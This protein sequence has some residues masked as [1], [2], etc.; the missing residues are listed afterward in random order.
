MAAPDPADLDFTENDVSINAARQ[1]AVDSTQLTHT[2]RVKYPMLDL[3]KPGEN[4]IVQLVGPYN[5]ND[6]FP[7]EDLVD[8]P[9]V[10]NIAS[11]LNKQ[12][13]SMFVQDQINPRSQTFTDHGNAPRLAPAQPGTDDL[14]RLLQDLQSFQKTVGKTTLKMVTYMPADDPE[15]EDRMTVFVKRKSQARTAS[16]E[17]TTSMTFYEFLLTRLEQEVHTSPVTK[18]MIQ[19]IYRTNTRAVRHVKFWLRVFGTNE[20]EGDSF[21]LPSR[22]V[23][24]IDFLDPLLDSVSRADLS[25]AEV[26]ECHICLGDFDDDSHRPVRVR[27]C[28]HIFGDECFRKWFLQENV[29]NGRRKIPQCPNRCRILDETSVRRRERN[30]TF[31]NLPN[32]TAYENFE[33]ALADLDA[34]PHVRRVQDKE[35][36]VHGEVM[37][38]ALTH[39]RRGEL[40]E[41]ASSTPIHLQ[42]GRFPETQLAVSVIREF[43]RVNDGC[44]LVVKELFNY[45]HI[46]IADE[47]LVKC[48]NSLY[49]EFL[50]YDDRTA[51]TVDEWANYPVAPVRLG[52]YEYVDRLIHRM[53]MF[54][55]LRGCECQAGFHQHGARLFWN[56]DDYPRKEAVQ[57]KSENL[58]QEMNELMADR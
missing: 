5:A 24:F 49:P 11:R 14:T 6:R 12:E 23:K 38:R 37:E 10:V 58:R 52:F 26:N 51:M 43:L 4:K 30:G 36:V 25:T 34:A 13:S 31:Y 29:E 41:T 54:Q 9:L 19:T 17:S 57:E 20:T 2:V 28:G 55:E 32:F 33:T 46:S 42:A 18:L 48:K 50:N 8:D 1:L 53:V 44:R 39:L 3:I 45:F 40:S 16:G 35:I 21:Y 7:C 15:A 27:P 56:R 22:K 47:L